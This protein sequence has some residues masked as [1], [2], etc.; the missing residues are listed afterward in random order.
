MSVDIRLNF[1]RILDMIEIVEYFLRS[2][3]TLHTL[4]SNF[5]IRALLDQVYN[6]INSTSCFYPLE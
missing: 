6:E 4:L 2:P 3:D 1:Q 5:L